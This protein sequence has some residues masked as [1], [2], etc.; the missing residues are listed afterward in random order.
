MT[1]EQEIKL[2]KAE[3]SMLKERAN[4]AETALQACEANLEALKQEQQEGRNPE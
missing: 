4:S 2:L 1:P 3:I